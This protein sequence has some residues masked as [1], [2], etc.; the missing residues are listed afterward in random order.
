M[1]TS[2]RA[3]VA[4]ERFSRRMAKPQLTGLSVDFGGLPVERVYPERIPDLVEGM[5]L[6]LVG[7]YRGGGSALI[8]IR[9][10]AGRTPF[11]HE[12]PLDLPEWR[13]EHAVLGPVWARTRIG[14]LMLGRGFLWSD[15]VCYTVGVGTGWLGELVAARSRR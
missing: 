8:T 1:L 15:L 13:E 3:G 4:A 9:G 11:V 14:A 2:D 7:R 10:F 5:P 12:V 6:V